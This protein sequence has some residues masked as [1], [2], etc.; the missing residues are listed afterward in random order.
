M[1]H[2][3]YYQYCTCIWPASVRINSTEIVSSEACK[4]HTHTRAEMLHCTYYTVLC[5]C[6][7][8]AGIAQYVLRNTEIMGFLFGAS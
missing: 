8:G 1:D 5:I 2:F 3:C 7:L 4:M 6:I